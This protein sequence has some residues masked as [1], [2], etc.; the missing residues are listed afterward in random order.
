MAI[1]QAKP[2]DVNEYLLQYSLSLLSGNDLPRTTD[3]E[4]YEREQRI[5]SRGLS[6]K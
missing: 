4:E 1:V 5:K 6:H 3:R 2:E